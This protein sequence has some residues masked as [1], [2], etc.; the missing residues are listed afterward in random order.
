LLISEAKLFE[1]MA[2][3]VEGLELLV[4]AGRVPSNMPWMQALSNGVDGSPVKMGISKLAQALHAPLDVG[5]PSKPPEPPK[6]P[7]S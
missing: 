5:E 6:E 4:K 2:P 7:P 3:Y 1:L